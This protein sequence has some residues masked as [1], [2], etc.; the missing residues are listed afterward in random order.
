M[1]AAPAVFFIHRIRSLTGS[2]PPNDHTSLCKFKKIERMHHQRVAILA[3]LII[4]RLC[5]YEIR[6]LY[7]YPFTMSARRT[8]WTRLINAVW[9]CRK[10]NTTAVYQDYIAKRSFSLLTVI[11]TSTSK[12]LS[13]YIFAN[14][15]NVVY[16]ILGKSTKFRLHVWI[17][18]FRMAFCVSLCYIR[19]H[20]S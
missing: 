12:Q 19:S 6:H 1:F 20:R 11:L 13:L 7:C 2:A 14:H 3:H 15:E 16:M 5:F 17:V 9:I 8:V 10:S 18:C 4:L